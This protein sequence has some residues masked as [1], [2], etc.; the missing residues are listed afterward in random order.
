MTVHHFGNISATIR[1]ITDV[2][3]GRRRETNDFGEPV[4][5]H[6]MPSSGQNVLFVSTL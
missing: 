2:H 1:W 4:T 6:P 5:F 3:G